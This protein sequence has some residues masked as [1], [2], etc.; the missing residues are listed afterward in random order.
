VTFATV[1]ANLTGNVTGNVSGSSGSC[2]G[3]AATATVSATS[4]VTPTSSVGSYFIPF[5]LDNSGTTGQDLYVDSTS[6]GLRYNPSTQTLGGGNLIFSGY[7]DTITVTNP[8]T[9]SSSSLSTALSNLYTVATTAYT[10]TANQVAVSG[11]V[12]SLANN[13]PISIP[14]FNPLF[15]SSL[16]GNNAYTLSAINQ[17]ANLVY[18]GPS[19]GVAAAPTFRSLASADLPAA[20]TSALGAVKFDGFTVVLNGSSQISVPLAVSNTTAGII[21]VGT[22]LVNT[23]G[24]VSVNTATSSVLGVASFNNTNFT[25]TSGN[26]NTAQNINVTATPTFASET[27]S[28]TS[29][30][31]VLG[32]TN[33]TTI[34]APAPSSP[35][36]CT[37]VSGGNSNTVQPSAASA[38]KF[39][40]G[41]NSNGI[42][43][44]AQPT[45]S[46]ISCN[47]VGPKSSYTINVTDNKV[48]VSVTGQTITLP[49]I[50]T[51]AIGS[52]Y[53]VFAYNS[54]GTQI[55]VT[56][57]PNPLDTTPKINNSS[58]YIIQNVYNCATFTTLDG[59]SWV[60]C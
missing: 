28:A 45:Q 18:A 57:I 26:V 27:L 60:S 21:T 32:V 19:T 39:A 54:S 15:S 10:G 50:S 38:N 36:T 56:V 9:S 53:S 31:L 16:S 42:I 14:G 2:T 49:N 34:T 37:I 43:S 4:A 17:N 30:Q 6:L 12:I 24:T 35:V 23:A 59:I 41:I 44:Y 47:V 46:N 1:T 33:T 20:T 48:Y 29:N 11:H 40:T 51:V 55:S 8:T 25:V 7:G 52:E 58:N 13:I 5:V 3:N 22:N